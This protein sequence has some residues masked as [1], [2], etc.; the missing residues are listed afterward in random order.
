[1]RKIK[2][3]K[4]FIS[5]KHKPFLIAEVSANHKNSI[6]RVYKLLERASNAGVD[7]VKF[8]TF[9]VDE[10]TL[11]VKKK[12]FIIK[13]QFKTKSWNYR[14]LHSIYKEAHMPFHWYK[15]IF[16]KAKKLGLIC[17]S[18]VFDEKSLKLLEK[19]KVP[20]YKIASL[21]S[22]HF[23]LIEKVALTKKPIIIST[24]TL[25]LKEIDKLISFFKKINFKKYIILHCVTQYPAE[26]QNINLERIR[27]LKKKYNCLIGYSDHSK[28]LGI[29]ISSIS[30]GA[31]V[32]EKHFTLSKKDKTLD[33][34]FSLDISQL[35]ILT[36]ELNNAWKAKGSI[37]GKKFKDEKMYKNYRRSIYAVKDIKKNEFFTK[38]NIKVIRPGFG[39][40]PENYYKV[41]GKKSKKFITL[42]S[43]IKFSYF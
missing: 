13:N 37:N 21:E 2:I 4:K 36:N 28:G 24:G 5:D 29:P 25:N 19:L 27:Y 23:P 40:A 35:N 6:N 1:M 17:F 12:D 11:N 14:T 39:L 7:A 42:G 8:Q 9:D 31:C 43:P 41:L 22:L 32:I 34:D 26:P 16:R 18:S 20:M 10:M 38:K 30:Y 3:Y 33:S 15:K